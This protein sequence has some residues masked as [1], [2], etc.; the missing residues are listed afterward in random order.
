MPALVAGIHAFNPI[1]AV[2]TWMARN[3]GSS[4]LRI[5]HGPSRINPT[6]GVEP[7]HDELFES[8]MMTPR[9][10]S[11]GV[12]APLVFRDFV[13]ELERLHAPAPK[14]SEKAKRV[15]R[16]KAKPRKTRKR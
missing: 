9:I 8:I 1:H 2:K 7:G 6:W 4:E 5:C 14:K 11:I 3:S 15:T 12:E 16:A 10:R 13:R